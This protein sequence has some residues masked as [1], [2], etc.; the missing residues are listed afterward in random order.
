MRITS[1]A[2][3]E[4]FL[5]AT[6]AG[7]EFG[8]KLSDASSWLEYLQLLLEE[9]ATWCAMR[10]DHLS[11]K[12]CFRQ[13][14]VRPRVLPRDRWD[15]VR[16]VAYNRRRELEGRR[17]ALPSAHEGRLLVYFPDLN[18]ADGAAEVASNGF[19]DVNN[20]PPYGSWVAY[21]ED[22]DAEASSRSILLSWVPD[23]FVPLADE[24]VQVNP[25]GCIV[26]LDELASPL[27]QAVVY[28]GFND[29]CPA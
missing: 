8:F 2:D 11:P 6:Q 16:D 15:C 12:D 19:F 23:A 10:I 3:A 26:W 13:E 25:E 28:V 20:A 18:L 9:A 4:R 5:R 21:F 27:R 1:Q 17:I 7:A 14:T 29:R 22:N 24:G